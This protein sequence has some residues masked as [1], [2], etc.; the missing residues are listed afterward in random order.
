MT[1]KGSVRQPP[2]AKTS[3]GSRSFTRKR[4]SEQ[5][6]AARRS[7]RSG[8]KG[9]PSSDLKGLLRRVPR[10]AWLCALIAFL[11]ATAWSLIVPPFQGKD[12]TDHFAY[13][14]QIAENGSLPEGEGYTGQYSPGETAVLRALHYEQ[15]RHSPGTPSISSAQDQHALDEALH[16]GASMEGVGQAGIA[17]N[18]PPLYYALQT[19]PYSLGK[20]NVLTQLQLMRLLGALFGAM[21]ALLAFLFLRELLPRWP[22]AATIGA[23]CIALQPAFA[24]MSGS[25]NPDSMLYTVA[26][27]VFLCLARAFRRGL[28]RRLAIVLGVCIAVGFLTKLNFIG[29]AFGVFIGLLAL[30]IREVKANGRTSLIPPAIA[31]GIGVSPAILYVLRNALSNH[32]TLGAV[33]KGNS[34]VSTSSLFHELSYIWQLYLP[35]LPGMPHYFAGLL[36]AKDVWFD[37]SVGLYGWF[38]TMFAPWVNDVALIPAAIIAVLCGRELVLRRDALRKRLPEFATYAAIVLGVLVMIGASSY[39]SDAVGHEAPFGEP[40]YL[41]PLLPLLGAVIALAVRGGGRRWAPVVGAAMVVLFL[42]HDIFS[43]LQVIAR[44]YG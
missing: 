41:L 26:A 43:Q 40:R 34:L 7:A 31:A 14:E 35:R 18:E 10:L 20:G 28:T 42:G 21:T 38:D 24:F 16:S 29:F 6:R 37:R 9:T 19:I 3:V 12:E 39:L 4:S 17:S 33:S 8:T 44:Y 27:G 1:P 30:A 25:V 32:P 36:T 23:V 13:V 2:P 5:A 11:N 15:V 22:W